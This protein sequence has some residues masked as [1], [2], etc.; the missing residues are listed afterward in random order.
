MIEFERSLGLGE[1]LLD[2]I[3]LGIL[4]TG[5]LCFSYLFFRNR[6]K[7]YLAIVLFGLSALL[8]V[9][10]EMVLIIIGTFQL[11]PAFGMQINRI[12]QA[13][14]ALFLFN[15]SY[16]GI[17]LFELTRKW[18]EI[19]VIITKIAFF[20]SMAIIA[21]AFI[22]PDLYI[23]VSKLNHLSSR[24]AFFYAR[25]EL[26]IV[27]MIRNILL[28]LLF[29]YF[30]LCLTVDLT[31]NRRFKMLMFPLI[32]III[33]F[34]GGIESIIYSYTGQHL[35]IFPSSDYS[36]VTVGITMFFLMAMAGISRQFID[37]TR[38]VTF[39]HANMESAFKILHKRELR[40]RQLA[41]NI[42]E[43]LVIHDLQNNVVI[44][45][46]PAYEKIW[47]TSCMDLYEKPDSWA[48][49]ISN[50]DKERVLKA[51][52]QA[53]DQEQTEIEYKIIR[54]DNKK[55]W[56]RDQ[57]FTVSNE[58][59]EQYRL[60][61]IIDDIT[62]RKRSEEQLTYL[63]YHDPVSGLPNRKSFYEY[64]NTAL[65]EKQDNGNDQAT[66]LLYITFE[67]IMDFSDYLSHD[68][69]DTIRAQIP[70]R[71]KPILRSRDHMFKLD[72]DEY[73]IILNDILDKLNV[74]II[75][76]KIINALTAPFHLA[77]REA[78]I[79][80]SIGISL[81][82][83]HG[84][85]SYTLVQNAD[86]ALFNARS[87]SNTYAIY[88][89][90]MNMHFLEMNIMENELRQAID[91]DLLELYYQPI[92]NSKGEVTCTEALIRWF[93]PEKGS[94]SPEKFIPLAESSGLYA[95]IG[96][97]TLH[98]ACSQLKK[99]HTMGYSKL[100]IAV[101]LSARYFTQKN[102]VKKIETVLTETG[103]DPAFLELEITE[104]SIMSNPE[105]V[106][107]S[108]LILKKKGIRFSI[109][110]FG[111]GYCALSY[112]Q[113]LHVN[114]LKVDKS[115]ILDVME[116]DESK[117]ITRAIVAMAQNLKLK[118]IAEGVESY[119]QMEFLL[120]LGVDELQGFLFCYPMPPD[121]L[122]PIIAKGNLISNKKSMN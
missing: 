54:P 57:I 32:G 2:A 30:I 23:S 49:I 38:E 62:K 93:H 84:S 29:V 106:I 11:D 96:D 42:N 117:E 94:I 63:V 12:E 83:E 111:T 113:R 44:Y 41:E 92:I 13:A 35:S 33:G 22:Q 19:N 110:D 16:F 47:G 14:A 97:W 43:V 48:D 55:R 17:Y 122:S 15:I 104:T 77:E 1:I 18:R 31:L 118:V 37:S 45:V 109:D 69:Q 9:T 64:F 70:K 81:Y 89:S 56:I 46:S 100:R 75:T 85:N 102:F 60:I 87:E 86:I 112:I 39:A 58:K 108:M 68:F 82:P 74:A 10:S 8:F 7:L 20:L 121:K 78:F 50:D 120:S 52:G 103:L 80:P 76:E 107:I 27:L 25:G 24:F 51:F 91:Q 40:F 101:N 114:T 98:K 3:S 116:N 71:I 79:R 115:F 73:T 105:D 90:Q 21:T 59:G 65:Q 26:G 61:R 99:W 36:R 95:I 4:L 72:G 6:F 28:C 66:A 119:E 88:E 5:I 34:Y 67:H 53:M